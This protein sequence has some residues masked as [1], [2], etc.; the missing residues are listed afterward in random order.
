MTYDQLL[1]EFSFI[2]T[3]YPE[4]AVADAKLVAAGEDR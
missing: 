2:L 3:T 1:E 4:A